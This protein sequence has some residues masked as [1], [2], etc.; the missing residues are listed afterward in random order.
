MKIVHERPGVTVIC[1]YCNSVYLIEAS[2]IHA[3]VDILCG[4]VNKGAPDFSAFWCC[5]VCG[6]SA[7]KWLY[8]LPAEW[9]DGIKK[10]SNLFDK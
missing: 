4:E 9:R 5:P 8:E 10:R 1:Q 2:D 6:K 7:G 3:K